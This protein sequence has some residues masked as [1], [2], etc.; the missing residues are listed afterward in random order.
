MEKFQFYKSLYD[1]ELNRRKD[2]DASVNLPLTI[3]GILITA[4]TYLVKNLFPIQTI[5]E[6]RFKHTLVILFFLIIIFVILYLTKSYNNFFN[7]FKYRNIGNYIT[8]REYEL[9]VE[10][11]NI[12]P[13]NSDRQ[14][15]F[16][17]QV[18]E[19][20]IQIAENHCTI[21]DKRSYDLYIAKTGILF[22]IIMTIINYIFIA[23][24]K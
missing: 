17:K 19:K 23:T 5:F 20:L 8:L 13:E 1:R 11:Y 6:I 24:I 10:K 15:D 21:N 7:G 2:L 14:I 12:K 9:S 16:D 18:L 3:L 22:T 4:N